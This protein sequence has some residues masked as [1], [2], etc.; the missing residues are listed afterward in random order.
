[1]QLDCVAMAEAIAAGQAV[2]GIP[3][4]PTNPVWMVRL[5]QW[6]RSQPLLMRSSNAARMV[7]LTYHQKAM[8]QSGGPIWTYNSKAMPLPSGPQ[9]YG[10]KAMKGLT[11]PQAYGPKITSAPA[12][13]IRGTR[14]LRQISSPIVAGKPIRF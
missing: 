1:M 9:A 8:P 4:P 3:T 10:P 12:A 13:L 7:A 11:P 6:V 14:I 2:L 5:S